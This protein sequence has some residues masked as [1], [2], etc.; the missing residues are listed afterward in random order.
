MV[1]EPR[2]ILDYGRGLTAGAGI[3]VMETSVISGNHIGAIR[4]SDFIAPALPSWPRLT[5]K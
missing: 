4:F 5:G 2:P 3:V 1:S